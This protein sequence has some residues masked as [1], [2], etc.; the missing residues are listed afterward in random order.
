MLSGPVKSYEVD[1]G[2]YPSALLQ[3]T[4]TL[5]SG[6][7]QT[8]EGTYHLDSNPTFIPGDNARVRLL[9]TKGAL[10]KQGIKQDNVTEKREQ[11]NEIKT[12]ILGTSLFFL[13]GWDGDT[14]EFELFVEKFTP[15]DENHGSEIS[16]K[17]VVA[18]APKLIL[19]RN[20]TNT[21]LQERIEIEVFYEAGQ[22]EGPA[23]EVI[24]T[25][26]INKAT[27]KWTI[28]SDGTL[29]KTTSFEGKEPKTETINAQEAN[30]TLGLTD[31]ISKLN[32]RYIPEALKETDQKD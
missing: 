31:V 21:N 16:L 9:Q 22:V 23:S 27:R 18:T 17:C 28:K 32:R 6:F 30:T 14:N 5:Y 12:Q 19:E 11:F 2:Q 15:A 26:Q 13:A 20:D 25:E 3:A 29:I 24:V 10:R 1:L 8:V 4:E 7:C